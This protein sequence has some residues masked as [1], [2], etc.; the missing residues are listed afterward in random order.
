[1][2]KLPNLPKKGFTLVEI[3][4]VIGIISILITLTVLA[5]NLPRQFMQAHDLT[6]KT[7]LDQLKKALTA[8]FKSMKYIP[9]QSEL[10]DINCNDP[11]SI[12]SDLKEYLNFLPCDPKTKQKYF[13]ESLDS[14]CQPC[15]GQDRKCTDFRLLT[16]IENDIDGSIKNIGCDT[17][18]GCAQI[19]DSEGDAYNYG[20]SLNCPVDSFTPAWE[21]ADLLSKSRQIPSQ[22]VLEVYITYDISAQ[23]ILTIDSTSVLN[24]FQSN[25]NILVADY[26][27]SLHD[28]NGLILSSIQFGIPNQ[29]MDAPPKGD[30]EY[31]P[32]TL[33]TVD[34]VTFNK[35]LN[36]HESAKSVRITDKNNVV[37]SQF[38]TSNVVK[39]EN[40]P[41]FFSVKGSKLVPRKKK[42]VVNPFSNQVFAQNPKDGFLDIVFIGDDYS[43]ADLGKFHLD[44]N[45]FINHL[46][47]Y[48]PFTSRLE[49]IYFHYIDNTQDLGCPGYICNNAFVTNLVNTSGVPWDNIYIIHNTAS[50]YGKAI[51]NIAVGYNADLGAEVFV[52]ELG[53]SLGLLADEYLA[54]NNHWIELLNRNCYNGTPPN[55]NW[56]GVVANDSYFAGCNYSSWYRSSEKSIMK[57]LSAKYF[58]PIS[59]IY[60]NDMINQFAGT[61]ILITPS[62]QS[63]NTDCPA[64]R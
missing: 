58:N 41:K 54:G 16:K 53:H 62:T 19:Y 46:I 27:L 52:H 47:T 42:T 4:I 59:Q 8:H 15:D 22:E 14:A 39:K 10:A 29:A 45:R 48:Q 30:E 25:P 5:I 1:M 44:V 12:P 11:S 43:Q 21:T 17:S 26:T 49:N 2:P 36:W 32:Q 60:I 24:S 64:Y 50:Y 35:T 23:N 63:I 37:I 18:T 6:R 61:Y 57:M 7:D 20:V 38:D 3:L 31:L 13:Y 33:F 51:E 28:Q 55:P 34:K 40:K 9:T 56:S